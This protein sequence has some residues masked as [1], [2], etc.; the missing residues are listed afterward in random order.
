MDATMWMAATVAGALAALGA[1]AYKSMRG[2]GTLEARLSRTRQ[3]A[4]SGAGTRSERGGEQARGTSVSHEIGRALARAGSV[5]APVGA[6]ERAKLAELLRRAGFG[7]K[8]ALSVFLSTK[9]ASAGTVAVAAWVGATQTSAGADQVIVQAASALAGFVIGG[10]V[11]EYVVRAIRKRRTARMDRALPDALDL[12][13]MCVETGLTI[14]R[15]LATTA[16]ELRPI[17]RNLSAELSLM[18]AELRIGRDRRSALQAMHERS[19]AEGLKDMAL[20]LMQSD[21]HGTPLGKSMRNIAHNQRVQRQTQVEAAAA[22]LPVLISIPMLVMIVPG[23]MLLIAGPAFLG[24]LKALG[25][26]GGIE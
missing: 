18:E 10:V 24:A 15:A 22:R 19:D 20:S 25:S 11:P 14:E 9:V 2:A 5:L 1:Y 13:I 3:R 21:R 7:Q 6:G 8:E 12:L 17:E 16:E 26:F 4:K 23:T